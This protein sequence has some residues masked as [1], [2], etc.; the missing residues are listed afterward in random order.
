MA[1]I[2]QTLE[3]A[4]DRHREGDL[5][6][7]ETLYRQVIRLDPNHADASHL[8]GLSCHQRQMGPEAV[9]YIRRAVELNQS[10][11]PYSMQP[12]SCVSRHRRT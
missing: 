4:V 7:A 12:G 3:R 9:R 8:L 6:Q 1:T 11:A 2:Q 10:V 5:V